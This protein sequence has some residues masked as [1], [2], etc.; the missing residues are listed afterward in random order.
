MTFLEE[1][2][3]A[4][5]AIVGIGLSLYKIFDIW[6]KKR[7]T[8]IHER[9]LKL[10]AEDTE[11]CERLMDVLT[12][13]NF[14][15]RVYIFRAHNSGG[16]PTLGKP[17]HVNVVHANYTNKLKDKSRRYRD[18]DV[19]SSYRHMITNLLDKNSLDLYTQTMEDS[20]LKSIYEDEGIKYGKIYRLAITRTDFFFM[21]IT[22]YDI[23]K[24]E[25]ILEADLTANQI[26]NI[27]IK[28]HKE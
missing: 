23:P 26:R 2:S 11:K 5:A 17:Y 10:F 12:R 20:L 16:K 25:Q 22:W 28:H 6:N 21:S 9:E 19:D 14:A 1:I 27:Y 13:N 24:P 4:V 15:D 3:K 18:I 8:K 7:K